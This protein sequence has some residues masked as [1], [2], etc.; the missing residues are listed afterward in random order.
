[1]AKMRDELDEGIMGLRDDEV[2]RSRNEE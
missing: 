1:M 2:V